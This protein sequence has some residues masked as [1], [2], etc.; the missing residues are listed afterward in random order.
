M[1]GSAPTVENAQSKITNSG[2]SGG[3]FG[4]AS[5]APTSSSGFAIPGSVTSSSSGFGNT[6][7]SG[8]TKAS[9]NPIATIAMNSNTASQGQLASNP[10]ASG[11]LD[12][13]AEVTKIYQQYNPTKIGSI[14][15]LLQKYKGQEAKLL[16]KL[17]KEIYGE[18]CCE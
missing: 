3:L 1:F 11:G 12:Y 15:S 13:K 17:K 18:C 7:L 2:N 10:V 4:N 5:T 8:A 14:D 6:K 16:E 9:N